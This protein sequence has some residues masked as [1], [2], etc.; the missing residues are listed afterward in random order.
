M[1]SVNIDNL[2][3]THTAVSDSTQRNLHIQGDSHKA[4]SLD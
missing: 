4:L 2:L 3:K 1:T